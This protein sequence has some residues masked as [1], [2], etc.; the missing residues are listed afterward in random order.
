MAVAG[1]AGR[2]VTGWPT[3]RPN[4]PGGATSGQQSFFQQSLQQGSGPASYAN[5]KDAQQGARSSTPSR[6]VFSSDGQQEVLEISITEVP[7]VSSVPSQGRQSPEAGAPVPAWRALQTDAATGFRAEGVT[8]DEKEKCCLSVR[9]HR[10]RRSTSRYG[11][12]HSDQSRKDM[13]RGV[14]TPKY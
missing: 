2:R 14:I 4:G 12:S 10:A 5:G 1:T 9:V 7:P 11:L 3:A 6:A 13:W 8:V